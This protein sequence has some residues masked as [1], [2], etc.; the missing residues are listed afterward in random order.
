M[1]GAV[2]P[3]ISAAM[4]AGGRGVGAPRLSPDGASVAFVDRVGGLS[5]LV[6]VPA[7]GGVEVA[8]SADFTPAGRGGVLD[9]FPDG[10]RLA[11][12]T[13]G[14]RVVVGSATGGRATVVFAGP[15]SPAAVAVSPDGTEVAFV[16]DTCAV[17]VAPAD[18]GAA[19]C[20]STDADFAVD[21][22]WSADGRLLAWQE[23]DVPA[24]AWDQSRIVVA[25]ADG[26]GPCQVV[27][28]GSGVSVQQP[29]FSPDGTR[30]AFLSDATG[31]LNLWVADAD[32]AD[33]RPLVAEDHEHGGPT[34]GPGQRSFAWSPDGAAIVFERNEGGFGRLGVVDVADGSVREMAR[35]VHA[36]LSW[37]ADRITCVRSGARTPTA[38]VTFTPAA[39]GAGRAVVD[40]TVVARGPVGG[41]E[42][43]GLVEP[44][45]VEWTG[46]DGVTIHG[47]LYRPAA[48]S[49]GPPPLVLRVHGGPTDQHR[50]VFD[51]TAAFLVDRGYAVLVADPRGST[52]WGRAFT[53]A[54]QGEWGRL[55]VA[56]LACGLRAAADRGWGDA[57]RLVPMGA[58]SG[59][60]AVLLLLAHHRQLC[61]A[62]IAFFPVSDLADMAATTHRFEAHYA[63][64]MV[65]PWPTAA[66]LYAQRS[67]LSV[68]ETIAG[69]LLL[70]HGSADEVVP[71]AQSAELADRIRRAGGFVDHHEYDGEGHGWRS[72]ATTADVLCRVESFLARVVPTVVE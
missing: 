6:V 43:A 14:G 51:T 19:R 66:E 9:W 57:A 27:A 42:E 56:D 5:R 45:P 39:L 52:G 28:G 21:P 59:G 44:E 3:R 4:C 13:G 69:P 38:V 54:L 2:T 41:F 1:P 72:S 10:E 12:A 64:S 60:M 35:G 29:R 7:S 68:A 17:M 58:S 26:M 8:V 49:G 20:L 31:W 61:A 15:G 30:L 23:W 36:D 24:M 47:R 71:A 40:R 32:G 70:L 65:G 55:D 37:A 48:L 22:A 18:G 67:P 63:T 53:Q 33:A 11:Y 62:G 46:D 25:A 50:V 34:W 16:V